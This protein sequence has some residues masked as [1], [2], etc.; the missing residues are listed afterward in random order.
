MARGHQ[1]GGWDRTVHLLLAGAV[2]GVLVLR[3]LQLGT[4]QEQ[5]STPRAGE[6]SENAVEPS[7]LAIQPREQARTLNAKVFG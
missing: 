3:R 5:T 1:L 7:V 6:A 4:L 2:W